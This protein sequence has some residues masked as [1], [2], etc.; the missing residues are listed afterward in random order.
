[1]K[2]LIEIDEWRKGA[3]ARFRD[4]AKPVAQAFLR[5]VPKADTYRGDD[6]VFGAD[7]WD[8]KLRLFRDEAPLQIPLTGGPDA[9]VEEDEVTAYGI[10]HIEGGLWALTPSLYMPGL[11]H[12]FITLYDVPSPVPWKRSLI[13]LAS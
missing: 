2:T 1:V 10:E 11:I 4:P 5:Y 13:V 7:G 12:V 9:D 3:A 6:L 8:L